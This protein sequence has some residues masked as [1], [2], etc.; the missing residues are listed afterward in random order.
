MKKMSIM[1]KKK[2][3]VMKIARKKAMMKITRKET[4]RK[5]SERIYGGMKA[6]ININFTGEMVMITMK[7]YFRQKRTRMITQSPT[8]SKFGDLASA[9]PQLRR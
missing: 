8:V 7:K 3:T 2:V 1:K 5:K 4:M 9:P 6:F